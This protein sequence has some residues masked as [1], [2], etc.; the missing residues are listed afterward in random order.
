MGKKLVW[1]MAK[2]RADGTPAVW[3]THSHWLLL[4]RSIVGGYLDNRERTGQVR[5]RREQRRALPE[6]G[7]GNP[8]LKNWEMLD[9]WPS[10]ESQAKTALELFAVGYAA[11]CRVVPEYDQHHFTPATLRAKGDLCEQ[12]GYE[13]ELVKIAE[14]G[15]SGDEA[16]GVGRAA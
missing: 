15:K 3:F 10:D 8:H 2:R 13:R 11:Y 16:Q 7:R 9:A 12:R 14:A 5:A 6:F 1:P 4:E